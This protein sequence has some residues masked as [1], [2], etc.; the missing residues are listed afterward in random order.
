[1]HHLGAALDDLPAL[2]SAHPGLIAALL[3]TCKQITKQVQ[4]RRSSSSS[5]STQSAARAVKRKYQTYGEDVGS[6][7]IRRATLRTWKSFVGD[8]ATRSRPDY[9]HHAGRCY[10]C[11]GDATAP[12]CAGCQELGRQMRTWSVDLSGKYAVVTG[13]R[14]KIGLE[15][16]LRLLRDGCFVVATTRFP[17]SAL[18]RWVIKS[19]CWCRCHSCCDCCRFANCNCCVPLLLLPLLLRL[20]SRLLSL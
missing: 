2:A 3:T 1:M 15:V 11:K 19:C 5:S 8:T 17:R 6:R 7:K 14:I 18:I 4:R 10:V 13:A 12:L 16:A 9:P 20:L